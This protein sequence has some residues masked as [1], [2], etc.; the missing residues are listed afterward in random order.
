MALRRRDWGWL[1]VMAA[2]V[3]WGGPI[4]NHI[5]AKA[6]DAY[7]SV[8]EA[9]D[10][11]YEIERAVMQY[12][13]EEIDPQKLQLSQIEGL[14]Q[15]L[16][17][18]S[19]FLNEDQRESLR[20]TTEGSFGGLGIRI[21]AV[22]HYPTVVSPLEDTPA[23]EVGLQSGDQIVEIEG[24]TTHDVKLNLI[25]DK[26]RGIPGT[27]V[28]IT[29]SR[30]GVSDSLDFRIVR[31]IIHIDAVP[32]SGRVWLPDEP[33]TLAAST[34]DWVRGGE[35]IGFVRLTQFSRGAAAEVR[36][37]IR[38]MA[39]QGIK[40]L[41][42]DLRAN[43]GGLLQ[44]AQAVSDLFLR[45][46]R[47][48]VSTRGNS[49]TR[50]QKYR[51]ERD[52][53]VP[54]SLPLVVLVDE[55]SASAS[56]IVA[57]AIQD[58]DRGLVIGRTTFGKGSVQ[59]VYNSHTSS[60]YGLSL[61]ENA[62]LKLTTAYYYS[63]SGRCIHRPSWRNG[64]QGAVVGKSEADTSTVYET[65]A[66]RSVRGGGGIAVDVTVEPDIPP[67]LFWQY[68]TRRLFFS[69][70]MD[71]A[72]ANPSTDPRTFEITDNLVESFREHASDSAHTFAYEPRGRKE[73]EAL[74]KVVQE[75]NYD[76]T[77]QIEIDRLRTLLDSQ[78]EREFELSQPYVKARLLSAISSR[79]WGAAAG[80]RADFARDRGLMTALEYL[81]DSGKFV[82]QLAMSPVVTNGK[83]ED[84]QPE[85]AATVHRV[86]PHNLGSE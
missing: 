3:V 77:V 10:D 7:D 54:P 70:A 78:K 79:L 17:T 37:A 65:L 19:D 55:A 74:E 75:A 31:A 61:S 49:N 83:P 67:A 84:E 13:V 53:V 63:P 27:A 58:N 26:L 51:S 32:F 8:A 42:L 40:G 46:G 12:Y 11:R 6:T 22:D 81:N 24:E 14:V 29:V 16:D 44:E 85:T 64:A 34:P 52:P 56:E 48:I 47:L 43:P 41:I 72:A 71:F 60:R 62:E 1:A 20:E 66:G 30:R 25:V 9:A 15:E 82:T 69:Y 39:A 57:G 4:F 23:W 73:L 50:E 45:K 2:I 76:S 33:T 28:N 80:R 35:R 86:A 68:R 5:D 18:F 38:D 59:T 36:S 21:H